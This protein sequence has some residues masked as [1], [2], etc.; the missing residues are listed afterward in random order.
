MFEHIKKILNQ[1]LK[2]SE[3]ISITGYD[4]II[5]IALFLITASWIAF[6]PMYLLVIHM[7]AESFFSYDVFVNGV[8]GIKSFVMLVFIIVLM[9]SVYLWGW[10][11]MFRSA[12]LT[13]KKETI[14]WG[15]IFALVSI[16]FHYI[17]T[18]SSLTSGRLDRI[19]W[20]SGLALGFTVWIS[21]FMLNPLRMLSSWLP[22]LVG[23]VLSATVPILSM[24]TTSDIVKTGLENFNVGGNVQA[25][26]YRME[27]DKVI[28]KGK[29]LLLTPQ[30]IF[31]RKGKRGYI[32]ISRTNDIFIEVG[33]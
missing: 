20:L 8:F 19:I 10:L 21:S 33:K 13:Q 30:Y 2:L 25:R 5:R 6:Y 32:N 26:I 29:L 27:D 1:E 22:P 14:V 12:R 24:K 3:E 4:V 7:K 18:L 15:I 31:L 16:L 28:R 11:A 17:L 9:S 23:I